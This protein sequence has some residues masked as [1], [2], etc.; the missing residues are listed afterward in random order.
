MPSPPHIFAVWGPV[1]VRNRSPWPGAGGPQT[2]VESMPGRR[3]VE[4]GRFE[5]HREVAAGSDRQ[6]GAPDGNGPSSSA[7]WLRRRVFLTRLAA[8]Q[9]DHQF[10]L[11]FASAGGLAERSCGC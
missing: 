3:M 6:D 5:Q 10:E 1:G 7:S 4:H 8:L 2:Q 9:M 11:H